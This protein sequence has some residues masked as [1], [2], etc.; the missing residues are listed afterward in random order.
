MKRGKTDKTKLRKT[1]SIYKRNA[2]K[3]IVK[4]RKGTQKTTY[5]NGKIKR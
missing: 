5:L 1:G 3:R 4:N 2:Y